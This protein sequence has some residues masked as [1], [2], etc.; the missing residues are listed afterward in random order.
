MEVKISLTLSSV[1]GVP[2][3]SVFFFFFILS[4]LCISI[5]WGYDH[6]NKRLFSCPNKSSVMK[7]KDKVTPWL[8]WLSTSLLRFSFSVEIANE[9]EFSMDLI[10]GGFSEVGA[11][12]Q[13]E[14]FSVQN[15]E[16]L[17]LVLW[18]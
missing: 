18:L 5:L 9:L 1:A 4:S 2:P 10:Q 14:A 6:E 16:G 7:D 15:V 3:M 12:N 17:R 8:P 13:R 11:E